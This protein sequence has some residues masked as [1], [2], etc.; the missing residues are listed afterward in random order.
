MVVFLEQHIEVLLSVSE[1]AVGD[2]TFDIDYL[3]LHMVVCAC[4]I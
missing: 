3:C 4:S 1:L 2:Y